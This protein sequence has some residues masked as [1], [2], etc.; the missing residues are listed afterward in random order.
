MNKKEWIQ[1]RKELQK[2]LETA[3]KNHKTATDQIAELE[4]TMA[5][6]SEKSKTFK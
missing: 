4:L 6:Y 3:Q 5:A 1:Q 2:H